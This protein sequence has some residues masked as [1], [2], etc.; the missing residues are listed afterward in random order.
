MSQKNKF[1]FLICFLFSVLAHSSVLVASLFYSRPIVEDPQGAT[2]K[3]A[4]DSLLQGSQKTTSQTL[5]SVE[6]IDA[7]DSK[8]SIPNS[9]QVAQLANKL[10]EKL[11]VKSPEKPRTLAKN[12]ILMAK[13]DDPTAVEIRKPVPAKNIVK[14]SPPLMTPEQKEV[15]L[16]TLPKEVKPPLKG[17]VAKQ[18][19]PEKKLAKKIAKKVKDKKPKDDTPTKKLAESDTDD[20]I[21]ARADELTPVKEQVDAQASEDAPVVATIETARAPEKK[22]ERKSVSHTE[23]KIDPVESPVETH[24][25]DVDE[26]A[27]ATDEEAPAPI[28]TKTIKVSNSNLGKAQ[29]ATQEEGPGSDEGAGIVKSGSA[30]G[31]SSGGAP[32]GIRDGDSLAELAGNLRPLYPLEDRRAR[33][34]GVATFIARVT[35]D[36]RV[37]EIKL[38]SPATPAM[39]AAALKAFTNFHYKSGQEG[40]IRKKF[41]F[42]IT[43]ESEEPARLRRSSQNESTKR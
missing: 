28:L 4:A 24:V 8:L 11:P 40:W 5:H 15:Q 31:I 37:Q 42:K 33:R 20:T 19:M 13:D 12:D 26:V 9:V 38:E 6:L 23:R 32:N 1:R 36:G 35:P 43:G 39:N 34:E 29:L 30:N 16:T 18:I 22:P 25:A 17:K 21:V 10:P 7:S 27:S 3:A 14:I 41:V 2:L